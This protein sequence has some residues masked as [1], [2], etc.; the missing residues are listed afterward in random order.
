MCGYDDPM[1]GWH[2]YKFVLLTL[3]NLIFNTLYSVVEVP[4]LLSRP[5][6]WHGRLDL[7][8]GSGDSY[9]DDNDNEPHTS[10]DGKHLE[11]QLKTWAT[12]T[13]KALAVLS[14]FAGVAGMVIIG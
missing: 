13:K 11:E 3:L 6:C 9:D 12:T 10:D 5:G 2:R 8:Q 14:L 7:H 4:C 1:E